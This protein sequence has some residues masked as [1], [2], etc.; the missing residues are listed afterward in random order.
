LNASIGRPPEIAMLRGNRGDMDDRAAV[1]GM[2][3]EFQCVKVDPTHGISQAW[4]F[5]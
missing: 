2:E 5:H 4:Y 1:H 3:Q